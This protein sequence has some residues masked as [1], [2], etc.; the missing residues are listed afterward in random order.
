MGLHRSGYTRPVRD[1]LTQRK[2]ARHA[3]AKSGRVPGDVVAAAGKRE[4]PLEQIAKDF[5]I[6]EN[7]LKNGLRN[8]T[9]RAA[10]D[11]AS[12]GRIRRVP[13]GQRQSILLVETGGR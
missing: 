9:T 5:G 11:Q 12:Q 7:C 2:D 10:P 8:A 13:R 3:E 6:S 1:Q 4:A